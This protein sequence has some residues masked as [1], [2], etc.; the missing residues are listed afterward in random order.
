M[1]HIN[2]RGAVLI[3]TAL[4]SLALVG[5]L[6]WMID[7]SY[8]CLTSE[9]LQAAADGAALAGAEQVQQNQSAARQ[10]AVTIAAANRAG[11]ASVQLSQNTSNAS[12][13]DVVLG[14]FNQTSGLFTPTL[15]SPN[16][17]Q[18]NAGRTSTSLSGPLNL[19]FGP[20]FGVNTVNVSRSAIAMVGGNIGAGII[21]L[22]PKASGALT[23]KGTPNVDVVTGSI[24]VNSS[25]SQAISANGNSSITAQN[26][27]MVSSQ[28]LGSGTFGGK[29]TRM[30]QA[31]TDPLASIPEPDT[32]TMPVRNYPKGTTSIQPGYYPNGL[33]SGSNLTLAP[34]VYAINGDLTQNVTANGVMFYL[35]NGT[36]D[37]AGNGAITITP[38]TSGTYQGISIWQARANTSSCTFTGNSQLNIQG[39]IYMPSGSLQLKGTADSFGNQLIVDTLTLRGNATFNITY[40]GNYPLPGNVVFLVK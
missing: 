34:G 27:Y 22:D 29:I 4:V 24:V 20:I 10:A 15:T 17:V 14:T 5:I 37:F 21:I 40:N 1:G 3:W 2:R 16:A 38:P 31:A 11:G 33:P 12:G 6:G 25:S 28:T 36:M 19:F 9:Q 7:L 26:L 32:S 35:I 13:G 39:T 18:V 8:G 30:S 23:L